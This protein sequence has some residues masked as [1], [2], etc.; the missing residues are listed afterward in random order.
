MLCEVMSASPQA[1]SDVDNPAALDHHFR[2]IFDSYHDVFA[3]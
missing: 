3:R 2:V 1:Q